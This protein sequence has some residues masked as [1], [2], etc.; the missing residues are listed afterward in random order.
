MGVLKINLI[1]HVSCKNKDKSLVWNVVRFLIW[2][3]LTNMEIFAS[4]IW[5][6]MLESSRLEDLMKALSL[7]FA[8][9]HMD[10]EHITLSLLFHTLPRLLQTT[11]YHNLLS[12]P[13]GNTGQALCYDSCVGPE[14]KKCWERWR[15]Y[16]TQ[17]C[18]LIN[19]W[20]DQFFISVKS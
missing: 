3:H 6:A 8:I 11:G 7:V 17:P 16:L 13:R 4:L 14:L 18:R 10:L 15:E 20:I 5:Q 12:D 19:Q 2:W 1:F 9:F